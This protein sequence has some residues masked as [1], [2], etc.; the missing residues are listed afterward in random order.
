MYVPIHTLYVYVCT[1]RKPSWRWQRGCY[2]SAVSFICM[3]QGWVRKEAMI[4]RCSWIKLWS[5]AL[6]QPL[7]S[8]GCEATLTAWLHSESKLKEKKLECPWQLTWICISLHIRMHI[9]HTNSKSTGNLPSHK[10]MQHFY[11]LHTLSFQGTVVLSWN[12]SHWAQGQCHTSLTPQQAVR[13]QPASW[14]PSWQLA[15]RG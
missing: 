11:N 12:P 15:W 8:I 1:W 13:S 9:T 2:L 7:G 5:T 6:L 3:G 4:L 14:L 10:Q